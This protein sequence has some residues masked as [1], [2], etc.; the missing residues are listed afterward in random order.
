MKKCQIL[1]VDIA[2]TNMEETI[3]YLEDNISQCERKASN[4]LFGYT[5]LDFLKM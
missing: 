5:G 2:V 4:E 1:G 3:R